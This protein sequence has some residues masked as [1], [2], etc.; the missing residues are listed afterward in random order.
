MRTRCLKSMIALLLLSG[1]TTAVAGGTVVPTPMW[2][3]RRHRSTLSE[4]PGGP[5]VVSRTVD[6]DTIHVTFHGQDLDVRL[7]GIDTPTIR[8]L[9]NWT[10]RTSPTGISTCC[11]PIHRTWTVITTASDARRKAPWSNHEARTD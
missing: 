2:S 10:A 5:A 3:T 8:G 11:R 9:W 1:C 4:D 6:G 7:I